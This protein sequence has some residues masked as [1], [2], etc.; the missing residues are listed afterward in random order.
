MGRNFG[1][2]YQQME[3]AFWGFQQTDLQYIEGI[4]G[5]VFLL[6]LFKLMQ[7]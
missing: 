7:N 3:H 6:F 1:K 5:A 4:P 2:A